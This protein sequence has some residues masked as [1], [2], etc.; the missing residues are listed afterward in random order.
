MIHVGKWWMTKLTNAAGPR[1]PINASRSFPSFYS[2]RIAQYTALFKEYI[3]KCEYSRK[4]YVTNLE[5]LP[6]DQLHLA[7]E[8]GNF[9]AGLV[10]L[11]VGHVS[12]ARVQLFDAASV[13]ASVPVSTT[14]SKM[15][16]F[17]RNKP[18]VVTFIVTSF[19]SRYIHSLGKSS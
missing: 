4:G 16:L 10:A 12:Q 14:K 1:K 6:P 9:D 5:E 11:E 13:D 3:P 17:W 18:R 15:P 7:S 2:L 8:C 19:T